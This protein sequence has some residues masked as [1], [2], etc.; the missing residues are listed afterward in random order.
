MAMLHLG[1]HLDPSTGDRTDS[2]AVVDADDL[3]THGVIVGMT[4][5]GK[6]GLG[7]VLLE[8]ALLAEIPALVIDPKGDLPNLRLVF[9]ELR[10]EDFRPWVEDA[11]AAADGITVDELA[12]RQ[13]GAWRDGLAGWGLGTEQLRSLQSSADVTI[14]TP[15]STAGVPLNVVG[16]LEPPHDADEETMAAEVSS[17]VSGLLGL[18][19]ISADPLSSREH[20]LLS[21]L[22][23]H[24][25]GQGT[26]LDLGGLVSQVQQPP[27]RKLGVFELE[28]FFP[29]AER[30]KLAV[31]LNGLLASPAFAAWAQ[32]AT[33]DIGQ[34]LHGSDGRPRCAVVTTS[35]LNDDERQF[36][37]TL[38][39][40]KLITWMRRQSGTSHLR[41]LLYM[42]EVA[43]YLPPTANPP[44][45][46]PIMLLMKQAR[47]FGVGVVLSTQNPVD[48]D[49]KAISNAG[50]WM[51]GRLQTERDKQRLLDGMSAATGGVDLGELS[52]RIAGL[53]KR[54]F[55][56]RRAGK[57]Q[58]ELFTTRWAMSYLRGPLTREQI[59]S[60]T[61]DDQVPS[62]P[63]TSA[64]PA[65]TETP[66]PALDVDETSVAPEIA[67]GVLVSYLD[68]AAPW[69]AT[70]G[71]R[72]GSRFEA[73]I[74]ARVMLRY[75]DARSGV[76]HDQEYEAV[77]HPLAEHLDPADALAVDHDPR[78]FA[79]SPPERPTYS[80]PDAPLAKSTWWRGI[81]RALVDHL[82]RN[83]VVEVL[84]NRDLKLWSRVDESPAEFE[85]RCRAAADEAADAEAAKLR[86]K[87]EARLRRLQSQIQTASDRAEVLETE[88]KGRVTEELISGV[89]SVLGGFL[90]GRR[91]ARSISG[92]V[93]SA[94]NRRT[95][96]ASTRQRLDAA[97]NK[98]ADLRSQVDE[99]EDELTDELAEI[100]ERWSQRASAVEP[101]A[102]S[103]K[104]TNIRVAELRMVWVPVG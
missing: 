102:I 13:A 89:G 84:A 10:G 35:H 56:M 85:T 3:T 65:V 6:T 80:I 91:S 77:F 50:T 41:A 94:A 93:N 12:E 103:A 48:L 37:T 59:A 58:P 69:A 70:V 47:A 62:E 25:W 43:G 82:Y 68:A 45:K 54:Q 40:S 32:G 31:R 15:G 34:M 14:Y 8:E 81:E 96:T 23:H 18:V 64:Q 71:A 44:T 87:Y 51:I 60:L 74:A 104:K 24:A 28:Q 30:T 49:Y 19:G 17:Y 76:S 101:V 57:E 72:P 27:L 90:G 98:V 39:L 55:L 83:E 11:Q 22:I 67:S 88:A 5:S 9:P 61:A 99:L 63:V 73:A 2:R 97:K 46:G 1:G 21:N 36:V 7:V 20:I 42:D 66:S 100:D 95:R 92:S 78:D 33:L 29:A 52:D 79:T 26:A 4:G 38:L 75:D 16:S 86:D 53:G